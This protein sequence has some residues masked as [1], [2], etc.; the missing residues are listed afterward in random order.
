M[1]YGDYLYL[2]FDRRSLACYDA[3]T[4]KEVYGRQRCCPDRA[5]LAVS[6]WDWDGRVYCLSEDGETFVVQAGREFKVLQ[7][8]R[9][10]HV[11]LA[12]QA[13]AHDRG[14]PHCFEAAKAAWVH[15]LSAP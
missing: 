12:G 7:R 1:V 9:F 10:N 3:N 6:P 13:V 11:A 15:F 2:L 5:T 14:L 8:N 4:G